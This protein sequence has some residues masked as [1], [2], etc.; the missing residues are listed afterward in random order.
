MAPSGP[1]SRSAGL[2]F[3]SLDDTIGSTS[4]ASGKACLGASATGLSAYWRM[5]WKPITLP[6]SRLP[7][8]SAAKWGLERIST[9]GQG[10]VRCR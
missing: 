1:I 2:K 8:I 5:P 3:G 6:T 9:P 10:R 4:T 7:C